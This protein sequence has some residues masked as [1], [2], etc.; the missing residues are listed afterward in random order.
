MLFPQLETN[1][2]IQTDR[3]LPVEFPYPYKFTLLCKLALPEG[4]EVEEL[5]QFIR[6]EG[7]HLQCR[8]M[9][10]KQG[11]TILVSYRFHLKEYIFLPEHYKQLQD[12]W[13]KIIEKNHTLIVLKKI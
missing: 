1:P 4:Y 6:A 11:N 13:T 10:Q 7:D 12:M 9:I 8:Y 2:F 5:P 3:V